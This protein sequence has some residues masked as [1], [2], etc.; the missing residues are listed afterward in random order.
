MVKRTSKMDL[1]DLY[2]RNE[3]TADEIVKFEEA[4]MESPEMQRHLEMV[5]GLREMLALY[6][7]GMAECRR[8]ESLSGDGRWRYVAFAATLMLAA[9]VSGMFWNVK[10]ENGELRAELA[11][12]GQP[13]TNILRIPVDTLRSS[14]ADRMPDVVI[15]K[16]ED[17]AALLLDIDYGT[18]GRRHERILF[19]L[20]DESGMVLMSWSVKGEPRGRSSVMLNNEQVPPERLWLRFLSAEGTELDKRLL[21]FR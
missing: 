17:H 3:L 8:R 15:K 20:T 2:V 14:T 16:P 21:E 5:L 19:E 9:F 13:R 10:N 6:P 7:E 11:Q 4:L 18:L 1:T 12:L